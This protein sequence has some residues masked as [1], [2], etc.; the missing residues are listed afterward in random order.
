MRVHEKTDFLDQFTSL[1]IHIYFYFQVALENPLAL[2]I[3]SIILIIIL[4]VGIRQ[5]Y[6]YRKKTPWTE[7]NK[8][9][10]KIVILLFAVVLGLFYFI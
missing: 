6:I 3:F 2:F 7:Q 4:F 5:F 9:D 1:I 8:K 10:L